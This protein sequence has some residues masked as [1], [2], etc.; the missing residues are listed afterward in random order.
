[1]GF[2]IW[3]VGLMVA[4]GHMRHLNVVRLRRFQVQPP[5]TVA[6]LQSACHGV[7][8]GWGAGQPAG[9]LSCH[10]PRR[11]VWPLKVATW[12]LTLLS[13]GEPLSEP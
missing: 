6:A 5:D 2:R 8:R 3:A 13:S 10:S 1:M 9:T 4:T 12:P 7:T 11:S